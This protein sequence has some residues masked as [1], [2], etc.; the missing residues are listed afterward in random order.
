MLHHVSPKL[1]GS[2]NNAY[3]LC[4]RKVLRL[5]GHITWLLVAASVVGMEWLWRGHP[6]SPCWLHL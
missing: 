5:G 4:S 2:A 1:A 3:L 6:V